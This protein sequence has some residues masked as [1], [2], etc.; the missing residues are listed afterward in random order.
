MDREF[1]QSVSKIPF[2][3]LYPSIRDDDGSPRVIEK[4]GAICE[5]CSEPAVEAFLTEM[6]LRCRSCGH[7][8][9]IP[10]VITLPG[11]DRA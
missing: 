8:S 10:P 4:R 1:Q 7:E 9:D 11:K 3:E 6:K 5:K 2:D